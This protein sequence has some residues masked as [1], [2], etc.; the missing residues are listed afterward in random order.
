MSRVD[1]YLRQIHTCKKESEAGRWYQLAELALEAGIED[2]YQVPRCISEVISSRVALADDVS[3]LPDAIDRTLAWIQDLDLG[4][5]EGELRRAGSSIC[6]DHQERLT[7]ILEYLQGHGTE[8][9]AEVASRGWR[10]TP[11]PLQRRGSRGCSGEIGN[12]FRANRERGPLAT[13][14][15]FPLPFP[16]F[17]AVLSLLTAVTRLPSRGGIPIFRAVATT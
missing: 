5:V 11:T 4:R 15:N 17:R 7:R 16:L 3:G 12:A 6:S 8:A 10:E 14:E 13:P 2:R 9:T 1:D